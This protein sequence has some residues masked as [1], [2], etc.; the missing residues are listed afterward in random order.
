MD[1]RKFIP[2]MFHRRLV[3]LLG[4]CVAISII[5]M[6]QMFRLSVVEGS[7]R[8][9]AAE[10]KLDHRT[11]LRTVRGRILDRQGRVLALDR[12]SYDLAVRYDVITGA[13]AWDHAYSE[14]RRSLGRTGWDRL[15]RE[16][17]NDMARQRLPD[18]EKRRSQLWD[19]ICRLGRI[20]PDELLRRRDAIKATVQSRAVTIW[21]RQQKHEEE[22]YGITADEFKPQPIREQRDAHVVLPRISDE[23]AFA[24]RKLAEKLPDMFE[25]QDSQRRDYPWIN[26]EV[27]MSRASLPRQLRSA[28][29]V[30]IGVRGVADHMLGAMRDDVWQ[31]DSERRPFRNKATGEIDL[32]WYEPGDSV[33]ARGLEKVFE[34]SLR[35]LRGEIRERGDSGASIKT[36]AAPGKDLQL[37]IDI[38]LQARVQALMTPEFGLTQVEPWHANLAPSMPVGTPLNAAAVVIEIESGEILAMV[39]M[40]SIAMGESM[41]DEQVKYNQPMVNRPVEAVYPPGSV[42]KPLVLSAAVSEGVHHLENSITCTGHFYE[43]DPTKFRCWI[44]REKYGLTTHGPLLAA[45][46][47]ARSCNIFFFTLGDR[48][49]MNGLLKWYRNFGLGQPLDVGLKYEAKEDGKTVLYGEN[50]GRMQLPTESKLAELRKL[51][52]IKSAPVLMGIGQGPVTWTPVQAANA[53]ATIARGGVIRDATLLMNDPRGSRPQRTADLHLSPQLVATVLEGLRGSVMERYGTGYH[54]TY[55]D[56]TDEPIINAQGVQV[57]AKTGTAQADKA[58][59]LDHSW[60]VGLVGPKDANK[61]MHAIAVIVENGGS[62]GRTAGPIANQIIRALQIE[63]YLPGDGTAAPGASESSS[64][65]ERIAVPD[66]EDDEH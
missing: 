39:S 45:E 58:K 38:A 10:D 25:V 36:D 2:S 46:A 30:T 14:V 32:G 16:E 59:G 24:F 62:G 31:E 50:D 33:G 12:A 37:T 61:P 5:L 55:E 21:E 51:G 7:E 52:Q 29:P 63:G 64:P 42:I 28:Q 19:E 3:L 18:W 23:V 56:H 8:L 65:P 20:T 34:D 17:R 57:W 41:T 1:R 15:S 49:G 40:P 66:H 48:L 9:A 11:F 47:L 54:I 26:A 13:W 4:V 22:M 44:Y 35:G 6:A 53:Y 27:I 60:F 43:N